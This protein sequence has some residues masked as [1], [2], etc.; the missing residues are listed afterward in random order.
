MVCTGLSHWCMSDTSVVGHMA[1][2]AQQQVL[3][4]DCCHLAMR[5]GQLPSMA[6]PRSSGWSMPCIRPA[7]QSTCGQYR[8]GQLQPSTLHPC[9]WLHASAVEAHADPAHPLTW[10]R[11]SGH[12]PACAQTPHHSPACRCTAASRHTSCDHTLRPPDIQHVSAHPEPSCCAL[13]ITS[14][15]FTLCCTCQCLLLITKLAP[16]LG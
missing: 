9:C 4:R 6:S 3:C 1:W 2:A 15:S 13:Q 14:S 8:H 11:G 7:S 16:D 10:K 12:R 5:P